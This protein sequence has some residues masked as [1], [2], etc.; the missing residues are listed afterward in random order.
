MR[1]Y[2]LF[3]TRKSSPADPPEAIDVIDEYG[4]DGN[5]DYRPEALEKK[6]KESDIEA[7]RWFEL[8]LPSDTGVKIRE[9]LT[10]APKLSARLTDV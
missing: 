5:P 10:G 8:S 2:V 6:L 3:A 9:A 7:A 1:I 4:D